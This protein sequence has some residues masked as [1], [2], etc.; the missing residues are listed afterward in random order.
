[1]DTAKD[2]NK[3]I[4]PEWKLLETMMVNFPSNNIY[5]KV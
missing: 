5:S 3:L 1:M 4:M 2:N